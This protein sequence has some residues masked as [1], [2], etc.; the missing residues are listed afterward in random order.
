MLEHKCGL[1]RGVSDSSLQ[2]H[3]IR[4][5]LHKAGLSFTTYHGQNILLQ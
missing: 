2:S 4:Y 5:R 1:T 3:K